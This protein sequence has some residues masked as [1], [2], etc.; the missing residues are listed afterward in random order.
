[1]RTGV[2]TA[3]PLGPLSAIARRLPSRSTIAGAAA[4]GAI[5]PAMWPMA[6]GL[7]WTRTQRRPWAVGRPGTGAPGHTPRD[8]PPGSSTG[9][10]LWIVPEGVNAPEHDD[11]NGRRTTA[12]DV[13]VIMWV[14]IKA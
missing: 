2:P 8:A 4:P 10:R 14:M 12:R 13:C 7:D 5:R 9:W 3:P 1:M 11:E 6:R